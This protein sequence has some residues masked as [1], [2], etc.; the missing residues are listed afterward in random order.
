[1]A[2][3]KRAMMKSARRRVLL[4]DSSKFRPPAFSTFCELSEIHEVIT[5]DGISSEHLASLRTFDL[6]VTVVPLKGVT[7]KSER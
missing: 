1:V 3:L 6:K 2:S 7:A 4:V 5:D